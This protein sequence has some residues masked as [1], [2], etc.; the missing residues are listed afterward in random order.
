MSL[1]F[2]RG[3]RGGLSSSVSQHCCSAS[4][5]LRQFK[6]QTPHPSLA[7]PRG[8]CSAQL[9]AE[10]HILFALDRQRKEVKARGWQKLVQTKHTHT[11]IHTYTHIHTHIHTHTHIYKYKRGQAGG[12]HQHLFLVG[13][14]VH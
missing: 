9:R 5:P 7:N 8:P 11:Y 14:G 6:G 3:Q 2:K 4:I 13:A 1:F 12:K 10:F